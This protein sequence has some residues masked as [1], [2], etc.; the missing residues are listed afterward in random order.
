MTKDKKNKDKHKHKHKDKDKKKD[1]HK[2]AIK[3]SRKHKHTKSKRHDSDSESSSDSSS[4]NVRRSVV[5]GEKIKLKRRDD[6]ASRQEEARRE[7]IREQMN[8]G[9]AFGSAEP[10][11]PMSSIER[12][13]QEKLKDKDGLHKMMLEKAQHAKFQLATGT[14]LGNSEKRGKKGGFFPDRGQMGYR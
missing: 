1:K 6:E 4:A 14:G 5:T 2:S 11:A 13:V 12:A 8:G 3:K 9:E 7:A 10:A